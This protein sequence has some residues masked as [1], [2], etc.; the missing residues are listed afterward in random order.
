MEQSLFFRRSMFDRVRS[1]VERDVL[2]SA[3]SRLWGIMTVSWNLGKDLYGI[4]KLYQLFRK[5]SGAQ[6]R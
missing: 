6:E 1:T 3:F 4:T 2:P 5:S